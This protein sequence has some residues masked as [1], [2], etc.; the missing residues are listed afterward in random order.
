MRTVK[1]ASKSQLAYSID[2]AAAATTLS[3]RM[4]YRLISNGKLRTVQLGA[5]RL[6]PAPELR[7]LCGIYGP[8]L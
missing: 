7:R 8:G 2:Q 1:A 3:R 5:R 4:I 6:V